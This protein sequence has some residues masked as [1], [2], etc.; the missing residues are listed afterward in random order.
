MR[1]LIL[2]DPHANWEAL[3]AVAQK[4]GGRYDCALCCGDLVD[5]GADPNA[6]TEWVR[7][8]CAAVIRGNHD[9]VSTGV[10]DIEWFNPA[11]QAA[12]IWTRQA[13]TEENRAYVRD[14]PQGPLPVDGFQLAHGSPADEDEY[15]LTAD[16]AVTAFAY[17]DEPVAFVGHT[18]LQGGYIWNRGRVETIPRPVAHFGRRKM[19]IDFGRAYLINPGSVGQ[20]RDGDPRAAFA[21]YD[22]EACV[23]EYRRVSYDVREAQ[24]KIRQ[25]GLPAVLADRLGVGR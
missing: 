23:V 10:E 11:A 9:K 17:L 1:Y 2:S 4:A 19:E 20:P 12:A 25:A 7:A 18:H 15:L 13:L 24:R 3:E 21:L 22:S 6:V 16:D 8:N 5:Y 14:L